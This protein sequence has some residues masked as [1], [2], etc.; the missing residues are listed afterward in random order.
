MRPSGITDGIAAG[1]EADVTGEAASM[2]PSGITDGIAGRHAGTPMPSTVAS[3]R[4]SGITDG[5][6][7]L[8]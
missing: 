2:R 6:L 5:I 8:R 7:T 3:M 4:P 1:D